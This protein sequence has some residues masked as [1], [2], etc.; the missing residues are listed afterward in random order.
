MGM[1]IDPTPSGD[2]EYNENE[3]EADA[4]ERQRREVSAERAATGDEGSKPGLFKR[5]FGK[6]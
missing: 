5:L 3:M 6:K 4:L 1:H 2:A